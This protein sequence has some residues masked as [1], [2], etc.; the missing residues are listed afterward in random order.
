M[1]SKKWVKYE[2]DEIEKLIL[3]LAKE[4]HSNAKI[5]IILRDQ[6]GIPRVR[7]FKIKLK[8]VVETQQKPEVPED[9]FNLMKQA[10]NLHRHLHDNKPD[11]KAKHGLEY[12]ESKI[13]RLGKYYVKKKTLKKG[14]KYDI[15]Q[16]KLLVK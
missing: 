8:K 4:G 1:S 13:R 16:A 9:M 7:E 11:A 12:I 10:V 2:K 15:E 3:K 6:Y 14:W 5:G